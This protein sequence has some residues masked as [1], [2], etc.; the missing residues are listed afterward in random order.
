MS[1]ALL[2]ATEIDVRSAAYVNH[3]LA[4]YHLPVNADV[5]EVVSLMLPEEDRKVNAL[6]IK[7]VGEIGATGVNAA[8][9]NAV[10]NATGVRVRQLPIRLDKLLGGVP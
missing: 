10:F 3:D 6:G 2:E 4:E 1:S 7:G 8:V 5:D 9:A